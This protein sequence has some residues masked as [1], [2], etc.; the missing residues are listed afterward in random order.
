[1]C[2]EPPRAQKRKFETQ[3][4]VGIFA[5]KVE[6]THCPPDPRHLPWGW[7]NW[8]AV[9]TQGHVPCL[10]E[11]SWGWGSTQTWPPQGSCCAL[12]SVY[13]LRGKRTAPP[14][15]SKTAQQLRRQETIKLTS[16]SLKFYQVFSSTQQFLI[17][18]LTAAASVLACLHGSTPAHLL[19]GG[20]SGA[21]PSTLRKVKATAQLGK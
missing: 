2:R 14:E 8:W 18:P 17:S 20:F 9:N 10:V 16:P 5:V 12:R 1:M 21:V 3:R 15:P 7:E 6:D 19:T 11:C 4:N 13:I